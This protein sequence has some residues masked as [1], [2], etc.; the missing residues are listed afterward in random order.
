[1]NTVAASV[2]LDDAYHQIGWDSGQLETRQK[3]MARSAISLA[4]QEVW[5]AWWWEELMLSTP[6][7][8]ATPYTA[9]TSFAPG[10]FC[11]FPASRKFYQAL[12]GTTGNA[13]GVLGADGTYATNFLYWARAMERPEGGD[14]PADITGLIAGAVARNPTDGEFYQLRVATEAV[15]V[16]GAGTTAANGIY[17]GSV[18]SGLFVQVADPTYNLAFAANHWRLNYAPSY[19]EVLYLLPNGMVL[20]QGPADPGIGAAPMPALNYTAPGTG[21]WGLLT[22]FVPELAVDGEVRAVGRQDPRNGPN[23]GAVDFE[24]TPEGIRLPGWH[25]DVPWI[26]RR[27]A[28]PIITGDDFDPAASYAAAGSVSF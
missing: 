6:L 7:P 19:V 18:A 13:P 10:D 21:L 2:I 25:T 3:Q 5:E 28:T 24:R 15:E 8:A 22:P 12:A 14:L 26:W 1:M 23:A 11:Y 20:P 27:R 17:L 9:A 16:S 4:L